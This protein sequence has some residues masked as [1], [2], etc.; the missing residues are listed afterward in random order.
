MN[1]LL[2][3]RHNRNEFLFFSGCLQGVFMGD[4]LI[5]LK[6]FLTLDRSESERHVVLIHL[7]A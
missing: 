3:E 1:G 5:V 2:S 6:R 4:C 7:N